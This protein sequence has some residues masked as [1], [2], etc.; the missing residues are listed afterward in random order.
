MRLIVMDVDSTL[1]Q[2]EVIDLLAARAGCAAEVAKVT[3][4]AMRGD[5]DFASS[6]RERVA[7]LAGLEA[8]V[9]DE[10]RDELRLTAGA[11]TLI[12]TLGGLGYKF[13]IV[14]GGFVQVIEPLAAEP[15]IGYVAANVLEIS[16]GEL[17]G[18]LAGPGLHR[19]G[20]GGALRPVRAAA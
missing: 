18:R 17:N 13:G 19:A 2:D 6:L 3:E 7:L 11:R 8:G 15:R 14:S 12:R 16:G 9:L 4:S 5:L 20:K 10:V 1:I